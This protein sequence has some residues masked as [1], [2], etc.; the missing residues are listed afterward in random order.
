[1][2]GSAAAAANAGA[3]EPEDALLADRFA[4]TNAAAPSTATAPTAAMTR[5]LREG[6]RGNEISGS[7][8]PISKVNGRSVLATGTFGLA[9][10]GGTVVSGWTATGDAGRAIAAGGAA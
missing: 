8:A 9:D 4:T 7:S 5:P 1:M 10:G 6:A 2:G 3:L